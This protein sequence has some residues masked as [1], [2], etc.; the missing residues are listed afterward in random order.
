MYEKIGSLLMKY[1]VLFALSER[2]WVSYTLEKL[3]IANL[4]D[5]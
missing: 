4:N 1:G 2:G 5:Q 3:S